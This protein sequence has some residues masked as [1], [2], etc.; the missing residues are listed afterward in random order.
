[1]N[2]I[3]NEQGRLLGYN[4]D[5]SGFQAALRSV[6]PDGARGAKCLLV[7]AGG[8]A[9][10]VVA[11]L[12]EEDAAS[13][14]ICNRTPARARSLCE[15]AAKWG[16]TSC[17]TVV[18]DRI[19]EA[20][21]VADL[22]VNATPVGLGGA[23]KDSPLPVD[24]IRGGQVVVD[25]AYGVSATTLVEAAGGRGAVAIDGKEM[26]IMQAACSYGLWTGLQ[27]PIEAMRRSIEHG[28]R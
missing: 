3:V 9:R 2:T 19:A 27:P 22:I 12:V 23:V 11:G 7:G 15:V 1:M 26:L 21:T 25:L 14:T 17:Q 20:V 5:V 28:E 10:A 24:R 13:V 16:A 18:S 6:L 8:A 4:T